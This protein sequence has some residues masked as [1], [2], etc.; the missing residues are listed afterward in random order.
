MMKK[1]NVAIAMAAVTMAGT[2]APVFANTIAEENKHV[3]SNEKS[4]KVIS[5]VRELLKVKYTDTQENVYEINATYTNSKGNKG[6]TQ[7]IKT[8]TDLLDLMDEE[9]GNKDIVLTITDKGHAKDGDKIVSEAILKY[10]KPSELQALVF[11]N[12]PK[13]KGQIVEAKFDADKDELKVKVGF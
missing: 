4:T 1:R 3:V 11:K 9:K 10:E 2:V 7:E 13:N 8:I 5:K 6:Q 12:N